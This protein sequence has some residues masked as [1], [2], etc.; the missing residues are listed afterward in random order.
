MT[1][2]TRFDLY[3]IISQKTDI[4]E[5]FIL[6]FFSSKVHTVILFLLKQVKP[7]SNHKHDKPNI[8]M[9]WFHISNILAKTYS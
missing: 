2:R 6:P 8:L 4:P 7:F 5:S 3:S 9:T 1:T